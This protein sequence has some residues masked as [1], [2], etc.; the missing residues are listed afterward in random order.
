MGSDLRA[1]H[2]SFYFTEV[3]W[4]RLFVTTE[5]ALVGWLR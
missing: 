1:G 3:A 4:S 5:S 2:S